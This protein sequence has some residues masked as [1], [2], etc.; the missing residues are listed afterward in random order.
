MPETV[1]GYLNEAIWKECKSLEFISELSDL[2]DSLD[3]DHLHWRKWFGEEKV[4]EI[5]LPKKYKDLSDFHKL[6][7]IKATWPDRV[8]SALKIF[9][10]DSLGS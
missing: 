7:I 2:C 9:V 4:E 10:S 3:H 6:I 5:E 8:S 1:K